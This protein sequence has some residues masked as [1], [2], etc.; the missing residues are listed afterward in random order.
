MDQREQ[1][2]AA[3]DEASSPA[4]PA[5]G[6]KAGTDSAKRGGRAMAEQYGRDFFVRIGSKGGRTMRDRHGPE[7]YAEIGK[8]GGQTTRDTRGHEFYARIGRLGG[9]RG[10]GVPKRQ[11]SD[12]LY[13]A[14]HTADTARPS[15]GDGD[16]AGQ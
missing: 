16:A 1:G 15:A 9:Q 6:P 7:F 8:R 13:E 11:A 10:R 12:R 2:T 14:Q 4:K 5:R 3:Q